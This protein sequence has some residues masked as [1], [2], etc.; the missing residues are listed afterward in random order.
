SGPINPSFA[1]FGIEPSNLFSFTGYDEPNALTFNLI[2]NLVSYTGKPPHVRLG[3]NTQD[4]MI[5]RK[6]QTE[7]TWV[8]NPHPIGQGDYA[9]DHMLIGPRFFEAANRFPEGTP[10]TWG[11]NLAYKEDDWAD[12]ITT[13]A[14]QVVESCP[15]LKL[16]SF[17]IGNE[18]DLYL[19]N[20]FRSDGW[21]GRAYTKDW[22][23]RAKV[24]YEQVLK[25][26]DIATDFFEP[27]CTASTSG[28]DFQI[29]DLASFGIDA[30][31][32]ESETSYV[33][34]WN[35]HDYYYYIGVSNYPLTLSHF[36]QLSTT[37]DQ[38]VSWS[39]QV[40][41]AWATPYGYAL[42]EMG[43]VG[44]VGL[45]GITDT[46]GAALWALNFLLYAASLGIATVQFHMTD[47]SEASL[48][49]PL[50][51]N[52]RR[53]FVR[54]IYYSFAAFDQIIG[55]TC[56][57]QVAPVPVAL[58]GGGGVPEGYYG[59]VRAYAVYQAGKWQ[60]L[61]LINSKLTS[62]GAA[63]DEIPGLTVRVALPAKLAGQ[64]V[65]L[66]YLSGASSNATEGT[67]WNG[68]EYE[69]SGDGTPSQKDDGLSGRTASVGEDGTLELLVRDSRAVV[70]S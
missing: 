39:K 60:S 45:R 63:G 33:A 13:M 16:V 24:I 53:P 61:V 54:P 30:Q 9:C 14:R 43:V 40:A 55:P 10:I 22:L 15:N 50:A 38:F 25:P 42:R 2:D 48:W 47:D 37:E 35:Q 8:K 5:F 17:E 57:A 26:N 6:D 68:L 36:M 7:W 70:A 65:V 32:A 23:E 27:G 52:G 31:A 4:Y 49:L 69:S 64:K 67:T 3:G 29:Q 41:Q 66:S 51:M 44:P 21:G 56:T 46:F 18:P 19:Q 1:G 34:S 62:D 28:T 20:A 58:V 11:L 59:Y 12:Q